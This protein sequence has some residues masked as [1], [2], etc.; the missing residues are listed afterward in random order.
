MWIIIP[1][2][3]GKTRRKYNKNKNKLPSNFNSKI[4]TDGPG[5]G[6]RGLSGPD[7]LATGQN[8]VL[9]LPHHGHDGARDDVLHE[10]GKEGLRREIGVVLLREGPLHAHE[11]QP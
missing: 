2:I 6:F 3:A 5:S 1:K 4:S 11:L 8:H 9:P 7:D 10:P